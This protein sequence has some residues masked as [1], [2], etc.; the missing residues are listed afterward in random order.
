MKQPLNIG[1]LVC[2]VSVGKFVAITAF[3]KLTHKQT[4]EETLGFITASLNYVEKIGVST[5]TFCVIKNSETGTYWPVGRLVHE[6]AEEYRDLGVVQI[7]TETVDTKNSCLNEIN[8]KPVVYQFGKGDP[9]TIPLNT[10][11]HIV[12]DKKLEPVILRSFNFQMIC[13]CGTLFPLS[14]LHKNA[15]CLIEENDVFLS[16]GVFCHISYME[17]IVV[18]PIFYHFTPFACL[19]SLHTWEYR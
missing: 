19:S 4:K 13:D 12:V 2:L 15:A 9:E 1:D 5:D 7:N 16:V 3:V 6:L 14:S 17:R 8:G 10:I 11:L 18:T